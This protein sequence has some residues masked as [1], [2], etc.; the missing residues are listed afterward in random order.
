MTHAKDAEMTPEVAE[1][2]R[3]R[4][5]NQIMLVGVMLAIAGALV[6]AIMA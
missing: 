5:K 6:A 1:M 2:I 4:R 3:S